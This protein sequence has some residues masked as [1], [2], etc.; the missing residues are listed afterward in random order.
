MIRFKDED[1]KRIIESFFEYLKNK[2]IVLYN[3]FSFQHELGK[4]LNENTNYKVEFERNISKFIDPEEIKN[5][6]ENNCD[7]KEEKIKREIDICLINKENQEDRYAIELKFPSNDQ[8]PEQMYKFVK[9]IKFMQVLNKEC[10]E[11]TFCVVVARSKSFY[12]GS[13][14]G[15]NKTINPYI[16]SYFRNEDEDNGCIKKINCAKPIF[17]PTGKDEE[18]TQVTLLE[19]VE[20]KWEEVPYANVILEDIK[21]TPMYYIIEMN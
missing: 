15:R 5:K 13:H 4:Y 21:D 3:E 10:F 18:R 2:K 9:D 6:Y 17:K 20:F 16:F 11:K 8:Y 19:N 12:L 14:Q 1:F 7:E